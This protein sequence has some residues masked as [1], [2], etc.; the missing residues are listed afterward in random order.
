MRISKAEL[1]AQLPVE[2]PE[3]LLPAI[4]QR[5]GAN[6]RVI[7]LDDDPT[8]TQTVHDV[9]VLTEWSE[10]ALVD[11]L[12]RPG[13][14]VYILTNSRSVSAERASAMNREI[15]AR[16][17]AAAHATGRRITVISRSDSTLR[18][19]YPLEVQAL[20]EALGQRIDG[21]LLI[22]FFLE[23]GRYTINDTHYVEE[24][25]WLTPAAETEFARDAAFGYRHSD[26]R[27]WA[28]E[29]H[30]GA[31]SPEAVTSISLQELRCGGP[32][33][34]AARLSALTDGRVCVVN[35]ATYRDLEVVV[36][37]L[38]AAEAEGHRYLYRTAASFVRVRGGTPPAPLLAAADL[39]AGDA[40]RG[41]LIIAGS[42]VNRTT[43]QIE[44][45]AGLAHVTPIEVS[46]SA[47]L[48]EDAPAEIHRVQQ[49]A[50]AAMRGGRDALVYTGRERIAGADE[51][52]TLGIGQ[53]IS[54]GLVAIVQGLGVRP[55]W[56]IAKGGITSSD[57]ATQGLGVRRAWVLGQAIPGVPIWRTGPESRWPGMAYVVFPGNV[58][59]PTAV[60]DMACILRG[61]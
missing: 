50:E 1:F 16:L 36:L 24:G 56:I 43:Q 2:W 40:G 51:Q 55:A 58:G 53:R 59:G 35:A 25:P 49:A 44:A 27:M 23:G 14:V 30:G 13:S 41:G 22:P 28:V 38:L 37:G 8:G 7:V 33:A 42:Y 60:A 26:L 54:Q 11:E 57:I 21:V 31:L 61:G 12:R 52:A 45:A 6:E 15:A 34:V 17:Q 19:H 46:T 3:P 39:G 5:I 18:G 48:G 32:D 29:K 4:R 10:P 9:P 47:L 20:Q